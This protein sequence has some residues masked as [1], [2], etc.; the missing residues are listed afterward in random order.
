MDSSIATTPVM[1][2][3]APSNS[4]QAE[5]EA[6]PPTPPPPPPP[7]P[8][9]PPSAKRRRY[10]VLEKLAIVRN[11]QRKMIDLG[12]S[13][14]A[15]CEAVNIHHTM[16][17]VWARKTQEMKHARN[18]RARSL[19][20]G[21]PSPILQPIQ[22]EL[23]RFIFELR[24]QGMSVSIKTVALKASQ[25]STAFSQKSRIAK[26]SAARRFVRAHGLVHRLGTHESQRS[27]AG[28]AADAMDFMT[29]VA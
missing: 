19:C 26:S 1:Q 17:G 25:L 12:M 11:V 5:E 27:P 14:R 22:D 29:T 21:P 13:Q 6:C 10:S 9:P 18:N 23:L 20:A 15:A 16:Y 28:T 2:A 8:P 4:L 7:A 3:T 24:E